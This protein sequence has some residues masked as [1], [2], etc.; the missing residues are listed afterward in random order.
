MINAV[1]SL[2]SHIICKVKFLRMIY[3]IEGE[4]KVEK[5]LKGSD[6]CRG[7][8]KITAVVRIYVPGLRL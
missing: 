2:R 4:E 6:L 1:G 7:L 8:R 3:I 5:N